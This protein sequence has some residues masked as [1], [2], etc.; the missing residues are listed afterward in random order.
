LKCEKLANTICFS[1]AALGFLNTGDGV[2]RGNMGLKDQSMA[3]SWVQQNIEAFGGDPTQ[4]TLFGE[5]AGASS[6][7]FHLL[8]PMSKGQ[9]KKTLYKCKEAF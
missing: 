1:L 7:S 6:A 2:V 3:L 4:V 8:S 9:F 5:S